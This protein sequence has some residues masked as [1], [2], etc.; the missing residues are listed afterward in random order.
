MDATLPTP[1][2]RPPIVPSAFCFSRPI[3]VS[4]IADWFTQFVPSWFITSGATPA[5]NRPMNTSVV[6]RK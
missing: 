4:S 5:Q 3:R 1:A 6:A 2:R